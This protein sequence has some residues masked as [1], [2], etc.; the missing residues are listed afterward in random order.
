M[1]KLTTKEAKG[2][3]VKTKEF[4]IGQANDLLTMRKAQWKLD[5]KAFEWNGTEIAKVA[6]K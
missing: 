4:E 1:V 5:D 3:K 2:R 6:K